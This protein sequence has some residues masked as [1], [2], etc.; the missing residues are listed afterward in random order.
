[1]KKMIII[2]LSCLA[3]LPARADE[4]MWIPALLKKRVIEEMQKAGFKLSAD[5]VY[6]VNNPSLKDAVVGLGREG[7]PF[8]HFCTGGI[9]SDE[10]LVVTNYHCSQSLVQAHSSLEHN[11]LRDGFWARDKNE[12]LANP[13]I[14]AS[15]L[16]SVEEVTEQLLA[17]IADAPP[18]RREAALNEAIT[19]AERE[20]ESVTTNAR[21]SIKAYFNG[22]R[23]FLSLFK[24]YRDVR[25]VGAPP[26]TIGSF[27]GDADN[28][29]WP[30]HAGD[31][32]LLRIYA[33]EDNEPAA[34]SRENRPY[35]P[36]T[37]FKI[38]TKGVQEGDFVMVFGYPGT[39]RE[40]LPSFAIDQLAEV[41][42]PA[43]I[44]IRTAKLDVIKQAMASDE[45][46]RIK[47]YA[48][49]ASV[50]NA[51]KKWQGEIKGLTRFQVAASK[52]ELEQRL[53]KAGNDSLVE[54]YRQLYD[55][56]RDL[57]L[58][59]N[60]VAEAGTGGAEI[61]SLVATIRQRLRELPTVKDLTAYRASIQE[62]AN[63][64]FKDYDVATDRRIFTEMLRLYNSS[65]LDEQWI[66]DVMRH[67]NPPGG[68]E[69]VAADLFERSL[70]TDPA[71]LARTIARLDAREAKRLQRD[72]LY[73]V[74]EGLARFMDRL[75]AP[76]NEIQ[77]K[78]ERLDR[79]WM[80]ALVALQ[81]DHHFYPDA[82]SS[83][84]VSFGKVAGYEARDAVF[85]APNTTLAG[86]MQKDDPAS[87]DYN[88]PPRLR[89]L[90][91]SSGD[92]PVCFAATSHTTGGNSGSPVLNADGYLVGLN[93]DRA[94]EGVMSDYA[95][96]PGICRNIS[97][98]IR[99]VLFIIDKYANAS[100]LSREM[101]V[102]P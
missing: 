19:R 58:A 23:Y 27:G 55:A 63:A 42:N 16:V 17:A 4:G 79:D 92:V 43:K 52:R 38:T 53:V 8:S 60:H 45:L 90:F 28:W 24:I 41:E 59:W 99:Y 33:G 57:L 62:T 14:T 18:S 34:Y 1:M 39:T 20:A 75:R 100:H 48:K 26:S 15:I 32:S 67:P 13:G 72:P 87:M 51:W 21:A 94:W 71:R 68:H 76:L 98:D 80:R 93:F 30:R 56:R 31:F 81:P 25:L 85:Y 64:F 82:N 3:L 66:P 97:V 74:M 7:R 78:L 65:G 46:L 40:Y 61:M 10:G 101:R 12:E 44:K 5:D 88:A 91:E 95:Y 36:A 77:E 96:R 35:K 89:E 49:A 102:V 70:F 83:F 2:A 47:Y 6:D 50:A 54:Q 73:R 9:V 86:V 11:Y 22:T 84:R 29:T 69:R 37:S